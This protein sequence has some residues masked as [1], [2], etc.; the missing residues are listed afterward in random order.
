MRRHFDSRVTRL[1]NGAAKPGQSPCTL[2]GAADFVMLLIR[3]MAP[4]TVS[5]A[6][7]KNNARPRLQTPR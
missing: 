7:D 4:D 3:W 2:Q 6:N 5:L 1:A